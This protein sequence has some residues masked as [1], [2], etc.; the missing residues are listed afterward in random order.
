AWAFVDTY[1]RASGDVELRHL[2]DFYVCYRAYVRGKVRSL[3][4]AQPGVSAASE[5]KITAEARAYFDLAWVQAGGLPEPL[6]VVA[7]G[8][9]ASGKTTLASALAGRLGLVHLSSDVVRKEL[10]GM[11]PNERRPETFRVGLYSPAMTARTYAAL[12]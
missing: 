9:P 12:R 1:V 4:L 3:R 5:A 10:A 8:L 2:L 11:R 6:V 7:M